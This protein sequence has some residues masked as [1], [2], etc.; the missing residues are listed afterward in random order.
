MT[1]SE[2]LARLHNLV[3]RILNGSD[4]PHDQSAEL[5]RLLCE[6]SDA[7]ERRPLIAVCDEL[8]RMSEGRSSVTP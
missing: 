1:I 7:E 8:G 3:E 4:T 2:K 5:G 6:L